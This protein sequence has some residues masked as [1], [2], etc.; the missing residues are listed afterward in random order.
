[1]DT[2]FLILLGLFVST[3]LLVQ[4]GY[5]FYLSVKG[6]PDQKV[7]RRLSMN[8]STY[9]NE[10]VMSILKREQ[11]SGLASFIKSLLPRLD[12]LITHT[13]MT[14]STYQMVMVM[15]LIGF[16]ALVLFYGLLGVNLYGTL[17]LALIAGIGG[18]IL[19]LKYRMGKRMRKFSDQLPDALDLIVRS[20]KAG[21]PINSAMGLVAEEMADP[22]GSEFGL[23]V[24]EMTYGNDLR[25]ALANLAERVPHPDL[26]YMVVTIEIQHATG[27]NLAEV[28]TGLSKVMRGRVHMFKRIRSLSAEGRFSAYIVTVL[29]FLVFG[30][31]SILSPGYFSEVQDDVLY[32]PML[33]GSL[34]FL[35]LGNF[36]MFRMVNFKV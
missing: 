9:S 33:L 29:P 25:E 12:A 8:R 6:I 18:P 32:W 11:D 1:M 30:G 21:H 31:L 26:K 10:Q 24:D 22:I 16:V 4:G 20:L 35:M 28:L 34:G 5:Y 14:I 19:Y 27:G 2:R 3:L 17:L 15:I 13:G 23:T 36:I 7:N